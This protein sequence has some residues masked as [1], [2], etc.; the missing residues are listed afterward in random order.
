MVR[1]LVTGAAGFIGS[2]VCEALLDAGHEV[3]G[4]D[5]FVPLYPRA[6]KEANLATVAAHPRAGG[7]PEG[8][9]FRFRELDLRTAAPDEL[10]AALDGV[11]WVFHLAAMGGLL[12]SWTDFDGYLTCNVQATQRLLEAARRARGAGGAPG[13]ERLVHASTSS[14]YG[15]D[16]AGDE[17]TPCAPVSPYGV[18]KLAAEHLVRAYDAQF[19]LP[20]TILRFFSVYG[21]RQRPDMGYYKFVEGLLTGR[22]VTVFGDGE[23]RRGNTYVGDAARAVLLAAERFRRGAVYNI[24]GGEEVSAKEALALLEGL[25]G[26]RAEVA[27]GPERPGEQRRTLADTARAREHLGWAPATPL[28]EGLGAQ[29]AWQ[30]QRYGSLVGAGTS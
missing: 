27:R 25:T 10:D 6:V 16:V 26:R 17:D 8:G 24:G 29:V 23:Q 3:L 11:Q 1:C 4:L 22:P 13:V 19:G 14:V 12:P 7:G 18:T 30:R 15:A 20:A 2:H 21:P 28:R 5:G 9:G